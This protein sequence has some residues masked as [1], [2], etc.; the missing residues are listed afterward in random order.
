MKLFVLQSPNRPTVEIDDNVKA[1]YETTKM[2]NDPNHE[3]WSRSRLVISLRVCDI[4]PSR[5]DKK[6]Q[7]AV[8]ARHGSMCKQSIGDI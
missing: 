6:C 7:N 5:L 3:I 4:R 8:P 1:V 2:A